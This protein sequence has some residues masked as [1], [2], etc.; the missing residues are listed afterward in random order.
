MTLLAR[1]AGLTALALPAFAQPSST[2]PLAPPANG[3]RRADPTWVALRGVTLHPRPGETVAHATVVYKDGRITAVLA[4]EAGPDGKAGTAD[5]VAAP[6]PAG[7]FVR[8]LA[9]AHCY[10]AFIDPY[11]EINAPQP[12][13]DAPGRH[14]NAKVTPERSALDGP[15]LDAA[16]A[17]S[18]RALGFAA[19]AVSPKGGIFRGRAAVVSLAK[20]ID[21]A[22]VARPAVYRADAYHAL[23]FELGGGYP[24]SQMGA[25]ALIRQTLLDAAWEARLAADVGTVAARTV[26]A[27]P[28]APARAGAV[29]S[30]L[31]AL[32]DISAPLLF[33]TEDELEALR[34]AGIARE[35]GKDAVLLGCGTEFRRLDAIKADGLSFILPLVFPKAPDVSSVGRA[36]SVELRD[37]M[38]WEQAPTNPRRLAAA[39]VRFALTSSKVKDRG[40]FAANLRKAILH[41]LTEDAALAALTTTPAEM[42]GV[43]ADLGTVEVGKRAN[44]LLAD[45]PLFAK[46]TKLTAI[47]VDGQR[48]ELYEAPTKLEGTWAID[49]NGATGVTL[50]IDD[51]N[52]I[53]VKQTVD[54][55]EKK[56]KARSVRVE[57]TRLSLV[58]D[59]GDLTE[60][61]GVWTSNAVLQGDELVGTMVTAE[62]ERFE[63]TATKVAPPAPAAAIGRWR[64]TR[65]DGELKEKDGPDGLT[66]E[67]KKEALTLTFAKKAGEDLVIEANDVKIEGNTVTFT[68]P[69]DKLGG[70]GVSTDV[71]TVDGDSFK[72]SSTLPDGSEHAYEAERIAKDD[73]K[74]DEDDAAPTDIPETLAL[75]FGPYALEAMPAQGT[76]VIRGATLWT[77]G[78]AGV[79]ERGTLVIEGGRIKA[80]VGP[81]GE[82]GGLT[83]ATEIDGTGLHVTPGI[84]DCHSHT[85]ISKGVNE[86]GQA[87]TAEVRIADVTDP[88]DVNWYRQLAGGVTAVN[89]LHGSANAIGGQSQTVKV[90]WGAARPEDMHLDG[91]APGIKFALGENPRR[92]NRGSDEAGGRYPAT[93][94][95]VEAL[96]RDRFTAARE[97]EATA[98]GRGARRDLELEALA[99]VLRG[100]RLVH[101][102]AYRQ[103]EILMLCMVA[104]DFGFRI[105]TFQHI[106]EGYKVAD[107]VRD[108]SGGGSGFTDWW[109]FK[110][111]VQDAIPEGLPIMHDQGVVVSFN[112]DS[113]ELAR[114]MN[115]EAGKAIKYG[116]LSPQ[117]ALKFVTLNPAKQL[118]IDARTGSLEAGKDADV[119]VWSGDPMSPYSVCEATYVDGRR[120]FSRDDDAAHRERIAKER[121]RLIQK[122]LAEK[123][124]KKGKGETADKGK[125]DSTPKEAAPESPKPPPSAADA[126]ARRRYLERFYTGR[127]AADIRGD[128]GCGML[129]GE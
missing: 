111:E 22:S 54:G 61:A 63:W 121:G 112:S 19:A 16:T 38:S 9:G 113:N 96:I 114:R 83:D 64:I 106:L 101:C 13:A 76:V 118:G 10:A 62:G 81:D 82:V 99:E 49:L 92:V 69:L 93:R 77:G 66:I 12:A 102:H 46:K 24:G 47:V 74:E 103:D 110:V 23:S 65:A 7:A 48:H 36:E 4:A 122:L 117:E 68:H 95:G 90:R 79:I 20:P 18:L 97:Y 11:V 123:P 104:K 17:E 85:G 56:A 60:P 35:M 45:G 87:I 1:I 127:D 128:C 43:A 27:D 51:K 28:G 100:E 21:D 108:Y 84:I 72:G 71:I 52:A 37:M 40:S 91:A 15:P 70:T 75:P 73:A 98:G 25:I 67:I 80:V 14:W 107:Y 50:E 44:L 55:K 124:K 89:S 31:A 29:P 26:A 41:G 59:H 42:L 2:S 57:E 53:T 3:P 58:F 119:A 109:A 8:D 34:A 126:W 115:V 33:D 120:L 105:G 86:G 30:C 5:D 39:G 125:D 88:D 129:H 32:T 78:S 6:A 94:L 116:G